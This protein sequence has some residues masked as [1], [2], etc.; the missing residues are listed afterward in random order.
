MLWMDGWKGGW[1]DESIDRGI[2]RWMDRWMD[3]SMDRWMDGRMDGSI[4]RGMDRWIN[5]WMD[6]WKKLHQALP[7]GAPARPA[8]CKDSNS[9]ATITTLCF[10]HALRTRHVLANPTAVPRSSL[11]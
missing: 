10:P 7:T 8:N 9:P 6:G 4:D 3:G 5:R 2:D 11:R 1:T